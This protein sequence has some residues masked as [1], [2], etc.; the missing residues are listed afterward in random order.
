MYENRFFLLSKYTN[1]FEIGK[2]P[3]GTLAKLL[4]QLVHLS[5]RKLNRAILFCFENR[6]FAV[7]IRKL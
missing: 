3:Q 6:H 7:Q 1:F 4:S 2:E 5:L